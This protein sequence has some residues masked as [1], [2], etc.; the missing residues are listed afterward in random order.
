MNEGEHPPGFGP[1][2]EHQKGGV[3]G[4]G[5][6]WDLP[7]A[8]PP[9]PPIPSFVRAL[10]PEANAAVLAFENGAHEGKG[11]DGLSRATQRMVPGQ[12]PD[13]GLSISSETNS[14]QD[15][16]GKGLQSYK[17]LQYYRGTSGQSLK[18]WSGKQYE[19]SLISNN[20]AFRDRTGVVCGPA[21]ESEWKSNMT[22]MWNDSNVYEKGSN[23]HLLTRMNTE[24]NEVSR[25]GNG[26]GG[27]KMSDAEESKRILQDSCGISPKP[28][29]LNAWRAGHNITDSRDTA[30]RRA[31]VLG[32]EGSGDEVSSQ[33]RSRMARNT[34]RLK[35]YGSDVVSSSSFLSLDAPKPQQAFRSN[36]IDTQ[37]TEYITLGH[38]RPGLATAR[39]AL[40]GEQTKKHAKKPVEARAQF[41]G[42]NEQGPSRGWWLS[43]LDG[44]CGGSSNKVQNETARQKSAAWV[45]PQYPGMPRL[46][47]SRM[48]K[49]ELLDILPCRRIV[50]GGV[51]LLKQSRDLLFKHLPP[52]HPNVYCDHMTVVYKPSPKGLLKLPIG[53]RVALSVVSELRDANC[54]VVQVVPPQSVKPSSHAPHITM[55]I[56][57]D[58][59][60][61]SAGEMV[62]DVH[63]GRKEKP[64]AWKEPLQLYGI[65]GVR[66]DNRSTVLSQE[67]LFVKTGVHVHQVRRCLA[68]IFRL[69]G[70]QKQA[71]QNAEDKSGTSEA[72]RKGSPD[73]AGT[74]FVN[75]KGAGISDGSVKQELADG[76]N[77]KPKSVGPQKDGARTPDEQHIK[78]L[79]ES[80]T[81][82]F[83]G[84]DKHVARQLLMVSD[85]DLSSAQSYLTGAS[86]TNNEVEDNSGAEQSKADEPELSEVAK[87]PLRSR[88]GPGILHVPFNVL[89]KQNSENGS[90]GPTSQS[91][92]SVQRGIQDDM[93]P[94]RRRMKQD[95]LR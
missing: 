78:E 46:D 26:K 44:F 35:G 7:P 58:A 53:E 45:P 8:P 94:T 18:E 49:D 80:L 47:L 6:K 85:W 48:T 25:Q 14:V 95:E 11:T 77:T 62:A 36:S 42:W 23:A 72:D 24:Q 55:S 57:E 40:P 4:S 87:V 41:V 81:M 1:G 61:K 90:V 34:S 91:N 63:A 32:S 60:P 54:Q 33:S 59:Q 68:H 29:L 65:V 12:N 28:D 39:H 74:P 83:E 9:L 17:T 31:L 3:S 79:V 66:L 15:L 69:N 56:A 52:M 10:G 19:S 71:A 13:L 30:G 22:N 51:F 16:D 92:A 27:L 38:D 70:T 2:K 82:Q 75:G 43:P 20:S 73:K 37:T 84:L 50:F 88:R 76:S 67:E 21:S 86:P 64:Q 93:S 5:S 89:E